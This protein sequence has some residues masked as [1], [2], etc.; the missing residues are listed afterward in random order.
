MFRLLRQC[1]ALRDKYMAV[2]N[3]RLGDNPRDHDSV[4]H[5]ISEGISDVMGVRPEA[6]S[7][8]VPA[9]KQFEPWRIYPSPPPPHWKWT[10]EKEAVLS[11]T[12][13]RR[14]DVFDFSQI[15]IPGAHDWEFE[16]DETGVYQLYR[17]VTGRAGC[18]RAWCFL[19]SC[20]LA[21]D[22]RPIFNIPNIR[23]YFMDL[24]FILGFISDGPTK[25][26]AFRRLQYLRGKFTMHTLLNE[27]Q[28][29]TEMKVCT[30]PGMIQGL[31]ESILAGSSSVIQSM[32]PFFSV[33]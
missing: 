17:D 31:A 25:S 5:G 26:F 20:P 14:R 16:I 8:Y 30:F 15:E 28:E 3:Q 22:K 23:E 27:L 10:A 4:F 12:A 24:D 19:L 18:L 29:M 33:P 32:Q 2:S 6:A 7:A 13:P 9:E 21:N 1:L 11:E